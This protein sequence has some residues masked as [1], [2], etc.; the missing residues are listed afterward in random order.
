MRIINTLVG[1]LLLFV[2]FTSC[3][4]KDELKEKGENSGEKGLLELSVGVNSKMENVATKSEAYSADDFPVIITRD[5]G[6]VTK[7]DS[8]SEI[9]GPVELVV[10]KYT[11]EAHTPGDMKP[12]M[13]APYFGKEQAF[14]ITQGK[15]TDVEVVC[16]MQN[17]E[18][19]VSYSTN[20][21]AAVKEWDI[22]FTDGKSV[23]AYT[24]EDLNP[25]PK[26]WAIAEGVSQVKV[27]VAYTTVDGDKE[28]FD[29]VFEKPEGG[30]WEGGESMNIQIQPG[31]P[32]DPTN[33]NGVSIEIK[34]DVSFDETEDEIN[35]SVVDDPSVDPDPG[36]D[37]DPKPEGKPSVEFPQGVY[38]LPADASKNADAVISAP[39]GLKSVKVKIIGGNEGFAGIMNNMGFTVGREILGDTELE[40]LFSSLQINIKTPKEGDTDYTFPVGEFFTVLSGL[41]ATTGDGH[42]FE[43]TVEDQNGE[44]AKATLKVKVTA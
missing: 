15:S 1:S 21:T 36:E 19:K 4:M 28:S 18:V 5:N 12:V 40:G 31:K 24:D 17:T 13:D 23:L 44:T 22:T 25:A 38:T 8:Y 3:E 20:F 2:G 7:F 11:I 34:V 14:E 35:V 33:P 30:S 26:Y 16:T 39:A 27:H 6:D 42:V 10:G 37:P 9:E 29:Q 32:S 41:G 43:I